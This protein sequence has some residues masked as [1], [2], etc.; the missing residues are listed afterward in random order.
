MALFYA[1]G[2]QLMDLEEINQSI[3]LGTWEPTNGHH[4]NGTRGTTQA[5]TPVG[6]GKPLLVEILTVYTGDAPHQFLGGKP[7]LLIVSGVKGAQTFDAAPRA[8]NQLEEN[9]K[10]RQYIGPGAFSKGSPIVYYTDCLDNST[11]L[12]SFELVV[13]S[14]RKDT[15]DSVAKMFASTAGLPIF[16]P[17]NLYLLAGAVLIKLAGELANSFES[18]PFLA[19]TIDLRFLTSGVPSFKSGH[20]IVYNDENREEFKNYQIGILNDG[21][22]NLTVAL[23]HRQSGEAYRGNAPYIIVNIDGKNRPDLEGYTPKLASAALLEQFY[24]KKNR[25]GQFI[26]TLE[27][28]LELYNDFTY[29]KKAEQLLGK[30]QTLPVGSDEFQLA[31]L[32]FEAYINNIRNDLFKVDFRDMIPA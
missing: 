26:N 32:L 22:D 12:C 25:S 6:V 24:G 4:E 14:F 17:A 3:A 10:D 31:K 8:I 21:F 16:V 18:R 20:Y 19:D 5:F 13:D 30:I 9:I 23:C 29:R 15:I 1:M 2:E 11:T 27:S 7:E 28:A